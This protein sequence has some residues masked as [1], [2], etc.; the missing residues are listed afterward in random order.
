MFLKLTLRISLGNAAGILCVIWIHFSFLASSVKPQISLLLLS[1]RI[2]FPPDRDIY[3]VLNSVVPF[4]QTQVW[5]RGPVTEKPRM[6]QGEPGHLWLA[7]TYLAPNSP[8]DQLP[9][10]ERLWIVKGPSSSWLTKW[11]LLSQ[12]HV[13]ITVCKALLFRFAVYKV[14]LHTLTH[15]ILQICRVWIIISLLLMWKPRFKKDYINSLFG[16]QIISDRANA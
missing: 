5:Y 11:D 15:L 8:A 12:W 3:A 10:Q 13:S 6:S 16:N 7:H 9:T 1:D 2:K 14:L 4:S